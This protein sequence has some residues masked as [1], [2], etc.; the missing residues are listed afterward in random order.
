MPPEAKNITVHTDSKYAIGVLTKGWKAKVNQAL[1]DKAKV[2][3]TSVVVALVV[4]MNPGSKVEVAS[5]LARMVLPTR[6]ANPATRP[7]P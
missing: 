6:L 1:I 4:P 3:E 5:L 7:A 2:P